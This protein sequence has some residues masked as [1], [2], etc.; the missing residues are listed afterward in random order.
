MAVGSYL[1]ISC[2]SGFKTDAPSGRSGRRPPTYSARL[3]RCCRRRVCTSSQL[4]LRWRIVCARF[5]PM[6]RA[7]PRACRACPSCSCR[8][9]LAANPQWHSLCPSVVWALGPHRI[10][11]ACP[12]AYR[13]TAPAC[14]PTSTSR[15]SPGCRRLSPAPRTSRAHPSCVAPRTVT[16]GEGRA[17]RHC[18]AKPWSTQCP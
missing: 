3:A 17:S 11:W 16:C 9:H 13:Q 6:T 10:P 1:C 15:L 14:S 2:R 12:T 18:G 4:R 5:T 7:G 8:R